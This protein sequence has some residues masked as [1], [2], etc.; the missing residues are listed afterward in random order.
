MTPT[1]LIEDEQLTLK[2][3]NAFKKIQTTTHWPHEFHKCSTYN[4][5]YPWS[6]PVLSNLQKE[7]LVGKMNVQLLE[8]DPFFQQL[9]SKREE[10][11]D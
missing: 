7:L 1:S 11:T 6:Y 10:C 3:I 4:I 9:S 8:D 5:N 2:R